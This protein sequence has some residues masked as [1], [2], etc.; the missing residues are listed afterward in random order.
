[1]NLIIKFRIPEFEPV[2]GTA[3]RAGFS[4][5]GRTSGGGAVGVVKKAGEELTTEEEEGGDARPRR[6]PAVLGKPGNLAS[7]YLCHEKFMG[8]IMTAYV[9]N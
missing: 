1:M 5:R 9:T 2:A 4:F 8:T 7:T 3:S 6:Q